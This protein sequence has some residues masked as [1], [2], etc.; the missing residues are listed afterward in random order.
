MTR[1]TVLMVALAAGCATL[2]PRDQPAEHPLEDAET[3]SAE[4]NRSTA[5]AGIVRVLAAEGERCSFDG[6]TILRMLEARTC[7]RDDECAVYRPRTAF[8]A[9]GCCLPV[10]RVTFKAVREDMVF[11]REYQEAIDSCGFLKVRCSYPCDEAVC[12]NGTCRLLLADGGV[13]LA[14]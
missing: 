12:A 4:E 9:F 14:R 5:D 11:R 6:G 3:Q 8:E 1:R 2:P 7:L 13:N 10:S